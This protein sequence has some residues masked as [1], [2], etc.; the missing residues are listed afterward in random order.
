ML[1]SPSQVYPSS[2]KLISSVREFTHAEDYAVS[3][4]RSDKAKVILKCDR[5]GSYKNLV[6]DA[7]QRKTATR[8][9]GCLFRLSGRL[10]AN[11]TWILRV[12]NGDHNH[13][14]SQD[15]SGHP[16]LAVCNQTKRRRHAKCYKLM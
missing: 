16:L 4:L 6:N 14:A 8:L 13:E 5:G 9:T 15:I 3:T 11:G 2:T 1:A 10:Q 12:V 7:P